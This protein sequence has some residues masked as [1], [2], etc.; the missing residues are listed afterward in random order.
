MAEITLEPGELDRGKEGFLDGRFWLC[1]GWDGTLGV[2]EREDDILRILRTEFREKLGY[3][4][5]A[6][7][8]FGLRLKFD[9]YWLVLDG[10]PTSS[11]YAENLGDLSRER[12]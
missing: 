9:T 8:R 6:D 5:Y 7:E 1:Y 11:H 4:D 10:V 3:H 2:T 12:A